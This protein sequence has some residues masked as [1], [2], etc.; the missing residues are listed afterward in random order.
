MNMLMAPPSDSLSGI[1]TLKDTLTAS[2]GTFDFEVS[3]GVAAGGSATAQL[4]L[5][6]M[7]RVVLDNESHVLPLPR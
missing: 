3:L 6:R 5:E 1:V 2:R 4:H 7:A